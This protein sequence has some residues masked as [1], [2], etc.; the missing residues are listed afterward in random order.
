[1]VLETIIS[2]G[3]SNLTISNARTKD[4]TNLDRRYGLV[5]TLS[6]VLRWQPACPRAEVLHLF[7]AKPFEARKVKDRDHRRTLYHLA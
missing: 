7:D 6:K 3:P 2:P 5:Y 1:M 4:T